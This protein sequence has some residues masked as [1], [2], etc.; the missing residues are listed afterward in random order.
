M[1]A[2]RVSVGSLKQTTSI[3][4]TRAREN[5]GS[6]QSNAAIRIS[7]KTSVSQRDSAR[8][9]GEYFEIYHYYPIIYLLIYHC[10]SNLQDREHERLS[11]QSA[12]A[13]DRY[14]LDD[15]ALREL[16]FEV[17]RRMRLRE[18]PWRRFR[19]RAWEI[20]SENGNRTKDNQW[21]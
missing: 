10:L 6:L 21:R 15:R 2:S 8:G 17:E 9:K 7:S 20:F 13:L 11:T 12:I 16:V 4:L 3:R 5:K 18:N 1:Q 14:D 19:R